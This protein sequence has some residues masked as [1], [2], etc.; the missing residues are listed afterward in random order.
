MTNNLVHLLEGVTGII[1]RASLEAAVLA[2]LILLVQRVLRNKLSPG[3]RF[4]LWYLL[5]IKLAVPVLPESPTSLFN[6]T[7]PV[8]QMIRK[9]PM[10][11]PAAFIEPV[12]RVRGPIAL[13]SQS[14]PSKKEGRYSEEDAV[15]QTNAKLIPIPSPTSDPQVELTWRNYVGFAWFSGFLLLGGWYAL[16]SFRF[17]R[18]LL[19]ARPISDL[20]LLEVFRECANRFGFRRAPELVETD[21]VRSPAVYGLFRPKVLLPTE[22]I[23]EFTAIELR[24]VFFHELSHIRRRDLPVKWL[25]CLLQAIH[26]FNPAVWFA[27]RRMCADREIATDALALS[28]SDEREKRP[29]GETILKLLQSLARPVGIPGAVG[30]AEDR[31]L[32]RQR[33]QSIAA[34]RKVPRWSLLAAL[35]L[36]ALVIITLTEAQKSNRTEGRTLRSWV[37]ELRRPNATPQEKRIAERAIRAMGTNVIPGILTALDRPDQ[38][39]LLPLYKL[40]LSIGLVK[41]VPENVQWSD[42]WYMRQLADH[43]APDTRLQ[44]LNALF[45]AYAECYDHYESGNR[46]RENLMLAIHAYG[47]LSPDRLR[48][49]LSSVRPRVRAAAASLVGVIGAPPD[50]LIPM[51]GGLLSDLDDSVRFQALATLGRYRKLSPSGVNEVMGYLQSGLD[52]PKAYIRSFAAR[53]LSH[54]GARA[55]PAVPRLVELVRME[56]AKTTGVR[57]TTFMEALRAIDPNEAGQLDAPLSKP[58]ESTPAE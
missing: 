20:A 39:A 19:A 38:T 52:D 17:N 29:Y 51:L 41:K 48:E 56:R 53:M 42:D 6:L 57:D 43:I 45:A 16:A 23:Y 8:A 35:V 14:G 10:S 27:F 21:A 44:V 55:Q 58:G 33:I 31:S 7:T 22:M 15:S 34:F 24:H 11:E 9:E 3:W 46:R 28:V 32:L 37:S 4:G 47:G 40:G 49:Q 25:M 36:A 2:V 1:V 13:A 12:S 50:E 26:W 54:W 18:S 5:L 30:I